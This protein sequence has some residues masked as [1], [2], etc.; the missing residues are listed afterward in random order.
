M[1]DA[2][3]LPLP[4]DVPEG[5]T[6]PWRRATHAPGFLREPPERGAAPTPPSGVSKLLYLLL[7]LVPLVLGAI[8]ILV[9]TGI[10]GNP[11]RSGRT[12]WDLSIVL[13]GT[14]AALLMAALVARRAPYL[15]ER[16]RGPGFDHQIARVELVSLLVTIPVALLLSGAALLAW[17]GMMR[18]VPW[19]G[20][21][22]MAPPILAALAV[23]AATGPYAYFSYARGRQVLAME[24]RFPDLLRDLNESYAA[25]MTM[26]QAIRVASR[27]DYGKLNG[28]IRR[29][30][31]QVSWGAS[32]TDAMQHFADRVGTPLVGRAVALIIKAT[33]AGGNVKD[34]LAAAARDAREIKAIEA[35]RRLNMTLYVIVIYVAFAV[36]LG[37][38]AALQ[39][40]LIPSVLHATLG[41]A[42]APV[43]GLSFGQNLGLVD[44][45]FIYF[46][47]GIVQALGSGLVAGVMGEGN[48]EA[49]LRHSA[50]LVAVT[51]LVLGVLL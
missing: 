6:R 14:A 35:D 31:N 47:V 3:D 10:I 40:L 13:L 41:V 22:P 23:L 39:G 38:T 49:G 46:G 8:V 48:L 11:D 50:I 18:S 33:R 45:Q 28:E 1:S 26:A 24:A 17:A 44:F 30:A 51:I 16:S 20:S 27:G 42:G 19:A 34:V 9:R 5:G 36:F 15:H 32:F 21:D 43:S 25:G 37:V 12:P 29:M 7:G 4:L 2:P